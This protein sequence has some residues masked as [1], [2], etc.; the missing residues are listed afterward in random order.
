MI[1]TQAWQVN[2]HLGKLYLS[3]LVQMNNLKG[4]LK[5]YTVTYFVFSSLFRRFQTMQLNV[6]LQT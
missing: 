2:F 4:I 6:N 3:L 1:Q 5:L